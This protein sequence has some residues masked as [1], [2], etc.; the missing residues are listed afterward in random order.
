MR[1][2]TL[3]AAAVLLAACDGGGTGPDRLQPSAVAG[4]Y[5]LCT[6]RF[7]P[8]NTVLPPADLLATVV[9]TDPPAGRPRASL[10]L[11]ENRTYDLVY[12]RRDDA[13][14]PQ[15]RGSVTYRSGG[16][17]L[18]LPATGAVQTE[19]LLPAPLV[20]DFAAAPGR[21]LS[22]E[23]P[24]FYGVTRESYTRAAGVSGEGLQ[25]TINGRLSIVLSGGGCS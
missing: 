5:E 13:F 6:L 10:S 19:L 23:T 20:L 22:Y 21:R 25:P 8:T 9:A 12:T 1:A 14:L 7:T 11:A 2:P 4:V 18:S 24:G 16:V 3:A 15:R 17:E